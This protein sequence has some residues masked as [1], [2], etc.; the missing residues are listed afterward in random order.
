MPGISRPRGLTSPA[1]A[2]NSI[3]ATSVLSTYFVLTIAVPSQAV[4]APLGTLGAPS[5]MVAILVFAWW[6]WDQV[7]RTMPGHARA[8]W[9]RRGALLAV[10]VVLLAYRHAMLQ[11]MVSDEITPADSGLVRFV[12]LMGVVLVANDG[13]TTVPRWHT[14]MR[15]IS[16]GAGVVAALALVQFATGQLWVDRIS[17]PGLSS[18]AANALLGRGAFTRP[19][20]T[21]SHPIEFGASLGMFLP[22][23]VNRAMVVKERRGGAVLSAGLV[24]LALLVSVSRTALIAGALG[25]AILFPFWSRRTKIAALVSGVVGLGAASVAVP[26]LLG[27]LRGLFQS[28]SNDPN[29]QSRTAGYSYALEMF[30]Y[31]PWLGRGYGTFLPRY[32]IFDNGYL[33]LAMEAGVAGLLAFLVLVLLA[34]FSAFR[35]SRLFRSAAD[36]Q[37]AMALVASVSVGAAC[38]AFFDL[39]AF[40]QSAS[41]LVLTVGLS[42]AAYRLAREERDR[43]ARDLSTSASRVVPGPSGVPRASDDHEQSGRQGQGGVDR[44]VDHPQGSSSGRSEQ[45]EHRAD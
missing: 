15:R 38:V 10:V 4:F 36:Q 14:L 31:N 35:A 8:Q 34:I 26:G 17:I 32:Y 24:V 44:G 30:G 18:G 42:G 25:L 2:R 11:P 41:C 3:D 21:A 45:I 7:H 9:V 19:S 20:A 13:I 16:I 40:P 28:S 39:F 29:I 5:T 23:V 12:A 43:V 22:I 33:Q 37:M 27:T 6:L 1:W